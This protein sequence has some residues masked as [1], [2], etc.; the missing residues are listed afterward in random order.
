MENTQTLKHNWGTA[1]WG[2]LLIW[3]GV[4]ELFS[5]LPHGTLALGIGLILLGL[6]AV[7]ILNGNPT[8]RLS[9][10]IGILAL[11]LGSL[12]LA[13]STSLITFNLPIFAI[14][15]IALGIIIMAYRL[16]PFREANLEQTSTQA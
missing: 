7:R 6:N 12:E 10:T 3:W 5:F 11:M 14:L 16:F 9:I 4:T 1:I 2:I 15:L 13:R 8:K